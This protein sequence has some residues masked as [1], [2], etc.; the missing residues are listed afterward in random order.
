MLWLALLAGV[1]LVVGA[2]N[3]WL[4]PSDDELRATYALP[5][6]RFVEVDGAAIHLSDEGSGVPVVLMHGS[7]GGLRDWDDW[8]AALALDYRVLRFDLPRQGLSGPMPA[9][10]EG[11]SG[12]VAV[13][14]ALV[15][16]LALEPVILVAT[17]SSAAPAMAWAAQNPEQ[18]RAMVLSNFAIAY[19]FGT[20]P[21]RFSARF[22]LMLRIDPW[23]GGWRPRLFWR[24]VMGNNFHDQARIADDYVARWTDLNNR[25]QRMPPPSSPPDPKALFG[26][27]PDDLARITV[28]TLLL[29]SEFDEELPVDTVALE[30]LDLV[31]AEDRELVVVGDCGHML[32][33]ECGAESVDMALPFIQRVAAMRLHR[34]R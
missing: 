16:E 20:G 7:F 28:P 6:S 24:E 18:L 31:A 14:D 11:L 15:R 21:A 19:P 13:L 27:A 1:A 3:G 12:N 30:A 5:Q 34:D 2:R 4:T 33:L 22:R 17:S 23:L 26:R 8:A 10:R 32:A 9:G 25:V 29:W